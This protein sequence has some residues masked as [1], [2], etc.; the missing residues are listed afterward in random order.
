MVHPLRRV[1]LPIACLSL[2]ALAPAQTISMLARLDGLQEVPANLS[3]ARGL[4]FV[5]IDL[6]ANTLTYRE[7]F[8]GLGSAEIA[9]HIHGFSVPGINSGVQHAQVLGSPKCGVWNMTPAQ[10]GNVLANLAYFNIHSNVFPGGEIRGQIDQRPDQPT[11]C[12]GDGSGTACPCGNFSAVGDNEGCLHSG[13]TGARLVGYAGPAPA[14]SLS[15]DR[16]VLH[17]LRAPAITPCVFF[18]G[19]AQIAGGAGVV[20]GE[21]LQCVGGA[22]VRLNLRFTCNGQLGMPE[23]GDAAISV[24]GGVTVPGVR[25]YQAWFRTGPQICTTALAFSLSNGVT[26]TWVP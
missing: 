5:A 19:T 13:G 11:F 7:V 1:L 21:G 18:Q 8:A 22:T 9:A 20:F 12:Y 26:V 14:P 6:G 15:N 3:P 23:P 16:L 17:L 25:H 2:A 4:G 10:Q 24:A